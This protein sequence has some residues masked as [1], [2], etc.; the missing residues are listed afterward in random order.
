MSKEWELDEAEAMAIC[1]SGRNGDGLSIMGF[2]KT[3][4]KGL[5]EVK[6]SRKSAFS[7]PVLSIGEIQS[8]QGRQ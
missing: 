7:R 2:L 6:S 8:G 4:S 3:P 1:L 5:G